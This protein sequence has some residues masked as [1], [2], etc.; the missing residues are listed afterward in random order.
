M[1]L[2]FLGIQEL[3]L[4]LYYRAIFA[5]DLGIYCLFC[6]L[7]ALPVLLHF[8]H[9]PVLNLRFL[10]FQR[11]DLFL[12]HSLLLVELA[13]LYF[14]IL[15]PFL[16]GLLQCCLL[17]LNFLVFLIHN[18]FHLM[19][20]EN[21][22]L[23]SCGSWMFLCLVL[24]FFIQTKHAE[25]IIKHKGVLQPIC[26][27]E[28]VWSNASHS[29]E[30]FLRL[31][32]TEKL[33]SRQNVVVRSGAELNIAENVCF[34]A[35]EEASGRRTL[36][37]LLRLNLLDVGVFAVHEVEE[38]WCR[39]V[40]QVLFFIAFF[41]WEWTLR[42]SLVLNDFGRRRNTLT[43]II[44][45]VLRNNCRMLD[46]DSDFCLV[47]PIQV[48]R[49]TTSR[50]ERFIGFLIP[51][52]WWKLFF[53]LFNLLLFH[54]YQGLALPVNRS[55]VFV[56]FFINIFYFQSAVGFLDHLLDN[57]FVI[58]CLWCITFIL[59]SWILINGDSGALG[60]GI[61][62]LNSFFKHS[63]HRWVGLDIQL[64]QLFFHHICG[65][66]IDLCLWFLPALGWVC[67]QHLT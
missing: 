49:W 9:I 1:Y 15:L 59:L 60:L 12:V 45:S 61:R 28:L 37:I 34:I 29:T 42:I 7:Q 64:L 50:I 4:F 30:L 32:H 11:L 51:C 39:S 24:S 14:Q 22:F 53:D 3:V 17:L 16:L 18:V 35:S 58:C 62:T 27:H 56:V 40:M 55:L 52:F 46:L 5:L 25:L 10:L 20:Q 41:H 38:F 66:S 8:L 47:D 54:R 33:R 26:F 57:G 67:P 13:L 43:L 48:P 31:G 63:V 44:L 21:P 6:L 65:Q 36:H 2:C 23:K 19:S